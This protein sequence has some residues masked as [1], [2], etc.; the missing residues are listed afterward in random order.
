LLTCC[1]E[2][3]PL[4]PK[5]LTN[6]FER[7]I[8][9]GRTTPSPGLCAPVRSSGNEPDRP[10]GSHLAG[11]GSEVPHVIE[12]KRVGI[13]HEH[14]VLRCG[15]ASCLEEDGFLSVEYAVADDPPPY[16]VDTAIVSGR[17]LAVASLTC[18]LVLFDEAAACASG[19]QSPRVY[20][21]ITV[22]GVTAE[23]LIA[24]VRAAAAGLR[25]EP[26][27]PP[28]SRHL[29]ERRLEVL[30]LLAS[31]ETTRAISIK[32]CYSERTI[33]SLIHDVE[34]ELSANSRAQAV[35]EAIRRGMI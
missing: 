16:E 30:R 15:I 28:A 33:K 25:V 12:P 24:S 14:D 22:A 29:D 11:I 2:M 5:G 7:S 4:V 35:A 8:H 9:L 27:P 3:L 1:L 21:T 31:G 20:A 23:Q 13:V 32:L 34:Y 10:S 17:A 6:L 19:A 18:P 26:P